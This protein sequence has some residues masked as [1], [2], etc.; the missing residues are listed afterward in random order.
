MIIYDYDK[1]GREII[2][3]ETIHEYKER[4]G[5]FVKCRKKARSISRP[6]PQ[7]DMTKCRKKAE[8]NKIINDAWSNIVN[9]KLKDDVQTV[10]FDSFDRQ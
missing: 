2:K 8:L 10:P 4:I 9:G 6:N 1:K 7:W 3:Q 5:V